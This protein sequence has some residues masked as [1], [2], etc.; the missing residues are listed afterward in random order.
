MST[1]SGEIN[2]D[3]WVITAPEGL[4]LSPLEMVYANLEKE[5]SVYNPI[6]LILSAQRDAFQ[7]HL[8]RNPSCVYLKIC[9]ALQSWERT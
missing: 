8:E 2:S 7:T 9:C 3:V 1:G 6:I 4:H 5:H